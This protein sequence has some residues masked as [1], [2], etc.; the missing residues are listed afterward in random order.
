ML[1]TLLITFQIGHSQDLVN[2][3]HG[4]KLNQFREAPVS[5]FKKSIQKKTLED[6]FEVEIFLIKPD[7]SAYMIFEYPHWD[8]NIIWSIQLYGSDPDLTPNF[9]NLTMG[10]SKEDVIDKIGEPSNI[11]NMGE[12]GELLEYLDTNY[13]V[14]INPNNQLSSIKIA[15]IY[16]DYFPKPKVEKIPSFNNVKEVLMSADN[17]KISEI[18]SPSMEIYYNDETMFFKNSWE[19]EIKKDLS[20]IYTLIHNI[21][22]DL[23]KVDTSDISEYEENMRLTQGQ[24][25]KHIIKLKKHP[26]I[27]EIVFKWEFG[28]YLIWEIKT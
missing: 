21:S 14:E 8:T 27:K 17:Q 6:G 5:E 9:K 10:M 28:Q 12:Y 11:K 7:S 2:E 15:E 3:L 4:F 19:N 25:V 1:L 18:L 16:P 22:K 24:D 23:D 13:S 26:Y 20:G